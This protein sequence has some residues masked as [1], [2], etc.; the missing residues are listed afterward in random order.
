MPERLN[1]VSLLDIVDDCD[2]RTAIMRIIE[3]V[4]PL[5]LGQPSAAALIDASYEGTVERWSF[6]GADYRVRHKLFGS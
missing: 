2:L 1:I 3:R 4:F 5:W 6:T